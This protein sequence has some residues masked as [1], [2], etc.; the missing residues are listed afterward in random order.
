MRPRAAPKSPPGRLRRLCLGVAALLVL[1][2][3]VPA[4]DRH[5]GTRY[6]DLS[7]AGAAEH[8]SMLRSALADDRQVELRAGE[9][10]TGRVLDDAGN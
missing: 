4:N 6:A 10:R 1:L 2:S 9:H 3:L 5:E 7:D 8:L